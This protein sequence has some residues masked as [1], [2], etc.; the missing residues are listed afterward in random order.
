[1]IARSWFGM[2]LG[3]VL[4]AGG[5]A[6]QQR[7]GI[8][9]SVS[10]VEQRVDLDMGSGAQRTFGPVAGVHATFLTTPWLE[11]SGRVRSGHLSAKTAAAEARDIGEVGVGAS[12]LAT[13][14]L[15]FAAGFQM[16]SFAGTFGTQ[17]WTSLSLGVEERLVFIGGE[18][19]AV[20]RAAVLPLVTVSG[21][22]NPN[23]AVS[24]SS[25]LEW[26]HGR[27]SGTVLY[28]LERYDF[29]EQGSVRR[30]EQ[31]GGLTIR[32]G[33][34][35]GRPAF[36]FLSAPGGEVGRRRLSAAGRPRVRL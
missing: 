29:P 34:R 24:V 32:M 8:A 25:G 12:V 17:R 26:T 19:R 9:A 14:S 23:I 3:L 10:L 31:F 4:G 20:F 7:A 35:L 36:S 13:P 30:L 21:L 22:P 15:A 5:A 2:A 16:R 33:L 6:G 28:T 27:W 1:M 18:L 11:L